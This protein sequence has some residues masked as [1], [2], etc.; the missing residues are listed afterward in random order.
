MADAPAEED[1]EEPVEVPGDDEVASEATEVASEETAL[2]LRQ[3]GSVAA[4]GPAPT[5]PPASTGSSRLLRFLFMVRLTAWVAAWG[6]LSGAALL[7]GRVLWH[8]PSTLDGLLTVA[9]HG[10]RPERSWGQ[11]RPEASSPLHQAAR[12]LVAEGLVAG[13]GEKV[14]LRL[15]HLTP[16]HPDLNYELGKLYLDRERPRYA[17]AERYLDR[18]VRV[19]PTN[20]YAFALLAEARIAQGDRAGGLAARRKARELEA[21]LRRVDEELARLYL[22]EGRYEQAVRFFK[23]VDPE[24]GDPDLQYLIAEATYED[25]CKMLFGRCV[26]LGSEARGR[27]EHHLERVLAADPTHVDALALKDKL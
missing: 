9:L 20:G 12:D 27:I 10:T 7:T 24:E 19:D 25:G 1:V 4:H 8:R 23:S 21:D 22:S 3:S 15:L 14:Y 2:A 17:D 11:P 6:V 5:P 26:F 16:D 18:A 13:R